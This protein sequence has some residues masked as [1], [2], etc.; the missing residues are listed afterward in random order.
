MQSRTKVSLSTDQIQEL[1]TKD[2]SHTAKVISI[3][4]LTEG[5]F[6]VAY[7][8]IISNPDQKLVLKAAP[9]PEIPVL[10]YERHAM[11][12]EVKLLTYLNS[13]NIIPVP[14]ILAAELDVN[15]SS[16]NRKYF[17]MECFEGIP[18]NK[19]AKT[20]EKPI[21]DKLLKSLA[22]Y[23]KKLNMISGEWY[24]MYWNPEHSNHYSSW[25][26]ALQG[27]FGWLLADFPKFRKKY[28]SG[29]HKIP[30]LL[31]Q[32]RWAF[33]EIKEPRLI[34]WDLWEGNVF[35][36]Q[37]EGEY[38]IIGIT[39]FERAIWGDPLMEVLF[40]QPNRKD[41]FIQY[42]DSTILDS[43]AAKVRRNFYNLYFA[44]IVYIETTVRSYP[45]LNQIANQFYARIIYNSSLKS[46]QTIQSKRL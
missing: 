25:F 24:G 9:P 3:K 10:T 29:I 22:D 36:A 5:W 30:E 34:H 19:A 40:F 45:R 8:V 6:N 42:Y 18:L 7:S 12:I 44:M 15:K 39:D 27:L 38:Q 37:I 28:P 43:E 35:V 31:N 21:F 14:K 2:I 32:F 20:L 17:W 4:E 16:I 11:E 23:Q 26:D 1:V 41:K 13:E 33:D 46:L